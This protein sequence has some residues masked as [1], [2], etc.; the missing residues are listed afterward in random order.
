V[1]EMENRK[2]VIM[3]GDMFQPYKKQNL[4]ASAMCL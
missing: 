1:K 3:K 2:L 4:A